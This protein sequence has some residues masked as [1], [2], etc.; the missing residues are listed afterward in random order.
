MNGEFNKI[1]VNNTGLRN[2]IKRMLNK[3]RQMIEDY[4]RVNSEM[5]NATDET[6]QLTAECSENFANRYEDVCFP[7]S[8]VLFSLIRISNMIPL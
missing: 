5:K 6:R 8:R 1:C 7:H 2:D 4:N 3:R